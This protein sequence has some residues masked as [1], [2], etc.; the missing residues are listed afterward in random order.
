MPRP[1]DR[2]TTPSYL[3]GPRLWQRR[4]F[5][6]ALLLA[7]AWHAIGLFHP[8][9]RW[10]PWQP[11]AERTR[12][13]AQVL[14]AAPSAQEALSPAQEADS[15][16]SPAAAE[17]A[18]TPPPAPLSSPDAHAPSRPTPTAQAEAEPDAAAA[19]ADTEAA[20]GA[21][22]QAATPAQDP[23]AS[24][25]EMAAPESVALEYNLRLL[26]HGA[27]Q[28]RGLA[29][30]QWRNLADSRY[31]LIWQQDWH[32][33]KSKIQRSYGRL[34]PAGLQP[35]RYSERSNTS[36]ERAVHFVYDQHT[37]IYSNNS[38]P[39]PLL[40]GTQDRL[41]LLL[42]MGGLL[43]AQ[44]ESQALTDYIDLRVSSLSQVSDW[45]WHIMGYQA[46]PPSSRGQE[47]WLQVQYRAQREWEPTI[48]IWYSSTG[49]LPMRIRSDYPNGESQEAELLRIRDI[50][51]TDAEI[52]TAP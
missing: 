46:A 47:Q 32:D 35:E 23:S 33:G 39:A 7:V 17:A 50:S 30:L 25:S 37:L 19:E 31:S 10:R 8:Y 49:F 51:S 48:T 18:P 9:W 1:Q 29:N 14:P 6:L 16:D 36:S 12:L 24:L 20:S 38:A 21:Q 2:P 41:S 40:L 11:P 27:V 4:G 15:A 3:Q 22:A 45:R 5:L 26:Q 42:Q 43:A 52:D 44:V 34:G 28:G 13:W